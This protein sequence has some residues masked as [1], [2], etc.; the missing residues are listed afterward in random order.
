[1][2]P[3]TEEN[4][5]DPP[6]HVAP[7]SQQTT[8]PTSR[9]PKKLSFTGAE[10][11]PRK[12]KLLNLCMQFK[13]TL[14]GNK[15][16]RG[17]IYTMV[18]E[19][20]NRIC[21]ELFHGMLKSS[22]V[23][24][25]WNKAIK[26]AAALQEDIK[27]NHHMWWNGSVRREMSPLEKV[28]CEIFTEKTNADAAKEAEKAA[29]EAE[30]KDCAA[31]TQAAIHKANARCEPP[32]FVGT[33][34]SPSPGPSPSKEDE[35]GGSA[36]PKGYNRGHPKG[37]HGHSSSNSSPGLRP[38]PKTDRLAEACNEQANVAA[39]IKELAGQLA[40]AGDEK[41]RSAEEMEI[42]VGKMK[43]AKRQATAALMQTYLQFT[44][45]G[46]EIPA[47]FRKMMEE[48]E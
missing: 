43:A 6:P 10:G 21:P 18:A 28:L 23:S 3:P 15:G 34:P 2:D 25:Q 14:F 30:E 24:E 39:S 16:K 37:M 40:G 48:G 36:G 33:G 42:E 20:L 29:E 17:D 13:G 22:I 5:A 7:D 27:V 11:L 41:K 45:A 44:Q 32:N 47:M 35:S 4:E 12:L 38:D 31:R 26:E 9:I 8:E 1:M 19:D 46:V